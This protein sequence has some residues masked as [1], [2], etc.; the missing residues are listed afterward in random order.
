[1]NSPKTEWQPSM[2]RKGD[3]P[4]QLEDS[5]ANDESSGKDPLFWPVRR[6]EERL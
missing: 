3:H 2:R 1:V 4:F 6:G 5:T